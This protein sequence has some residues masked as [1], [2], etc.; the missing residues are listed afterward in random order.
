MIRRNF[1][2]FVSCWFCGAK[3]TEQYIKEY[4]PDCGKHKN[5]IDEEQCPY[6]GYH[7][8]FIEEENE[9]IKL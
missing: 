6:C 2:G 5:D 7:N 9:I 8:T 3:L 4:I 1:K